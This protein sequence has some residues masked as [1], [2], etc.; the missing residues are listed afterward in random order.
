MNFGGRQKPG[1]IIREEVQREKLSERAGM[2]ALKFEKL[3]E[4]EEVC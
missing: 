2:R 4:G 3:E 1:Y